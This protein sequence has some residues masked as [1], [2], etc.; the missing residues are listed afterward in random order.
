MKKQK[1]L[2]I[3]ILSKYKVLGI[4]FNKYL[5][6]YNINTYEYLYIMPYF[7][8]LFYELFLSFTNIDFFKSQLDQFFNLF[9]YIFNRVTKNI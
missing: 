6:N 5:N 1:K 7:D 4:L 8:N 9:I 2:F 3:N